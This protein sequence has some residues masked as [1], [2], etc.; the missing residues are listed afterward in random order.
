MPDDLID[1]IH[2][3]S[4]DAE[5]EYQHALDMAKKHQTVRYLVGGAAI[6]AGALASLAAAG[7]GPSTLGVYAGV[8]ASVL[9]AVQTF[10][11][12]GEL[13]SLHWRKRAGYG[14]LVRAYDLLATKEPTLAEVQNLDKRW[15][16]VE[17]SAPA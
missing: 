7:I 14:G 6:L 1:K 4:K 10:I 8:A 3:R 5:I 15:D 17:G 2:K 12:S 9:A 13:E 11:K 16:E